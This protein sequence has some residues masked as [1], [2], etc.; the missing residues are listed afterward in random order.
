MNPDLLNQ[1]DSSNTAITSKFIRLNGFFV[2]DSPCIFCTKK[3]VRVD[4]CYDLIRFLDDGGIGLRNV[5]FRDA[6][7]QNDV[8]SI[9][10]HDIS[11]NHEYQYSQSFNN[12]TACSWLLVEK[13]YFDEELQGLGF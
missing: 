2:I 12:D 3:I 8:L 13:N 7:L 11:T 6:T 4:D 5:Q 10:V 1:N 9:F